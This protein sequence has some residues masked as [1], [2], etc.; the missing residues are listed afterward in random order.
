MK[1]D[2]S[3][4]ETQTVYIKNDIMYIPLYKGKGWVGPG[5]FHENNKIYTEED[6]IAQK[7]LKSSYPLWPRLNDA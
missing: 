7:A 5:Y 4:T 3:P 1:K 2:A 6:F